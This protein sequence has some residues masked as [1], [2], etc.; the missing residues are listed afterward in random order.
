MSR[1]KDLFTNTYI[2]NTW[3]SG[4]E[5]RSGAGSS[6]AYTIHFR[7][8]LLDI[9]KDFNIKTIFDCSC[10]DWNWM[11][12]IK[13]FLPNYIGNDI[14]SEMIESNK[15]KYESENI[16]FICSDMLDTLR[17]YEDASIDLIICRHTLEHLSNEYALNIITEIKRVA[18]Y[19][20]ITSNLGNNSELDLND[21]H[22]SR[23]VNLDC[24][25][26]YEILGNSYK[27]YYDSIGEPSNQLHTNCNFYKFK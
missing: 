22:H 17:T 8:N 15:E 14:V 12:E 1:L 3:G 2:N 25:A 20:L 13:E 27:K 19:A 21:G 26:Y 11:K 16:K 23:L 9:I 6:L 18:K 5:S 7:K 10:G 4:G 24:D